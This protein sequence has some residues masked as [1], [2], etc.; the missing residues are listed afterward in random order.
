MRRGLWGGGVCVFVWV[1]LCVSLCADLS[2]LLET[3]L[4][5]CWW[6]LLITLSPLW[7][8]RGGLLI[9]LFTLAWCFVKW[10]VTDAGT[11][12]NWLVNLHTAVPTNLIAFNYHFWFANGPLLLGS[13]LTLAQDRVCM[14]NLGPR[15]L[16]NKIGVKVANTLPQTHFLN[17][18]LQCFLNKADKVPLNYQEWNPNNRS[19]RVFVSEGS[20]TAYH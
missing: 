4:L 16:C 20:S 11:E 8:W 5:K 1:C 7:A 2:I 9:G 15:Q 3:M 17:K 18:S 12:T 10:D 6:T 13:S 14:V 19:Q